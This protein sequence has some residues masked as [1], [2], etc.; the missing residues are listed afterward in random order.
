MRLRSIAS[1]HRA[2]D[3]LAACCLAGAVATVTLSCAHAG[4]ARTVT[5]R[6]REFLPASLEVAAG[7]SVRVVNDDAPLVHHVYV[8]AEGLSF[9]SGDQNP[10]DAAT[11]RFDRPGHY[12][13]L[14]AI[15]PKM[16]L[17]V[18]VD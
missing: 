6:G 10:G 2:L 11:I 7:D 4:G 15:H 16:L 17:A 14:C 18:T 8:D 3:V 13:L 9:D 12:T 5:Q 1:G